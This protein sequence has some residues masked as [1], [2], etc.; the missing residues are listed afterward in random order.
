MCPVS[1][2]LSANTEGWTAFIS[3]VWPGVK[4]DGVWMPA[5]VISIGE[6][7]RSSPALRRPR[8]LLDLSPSQQQN[9]SCSAAERGCPLPKA[10]DLR[11]STSGYSSSHSHDQSTSEMANSCAEN[12]SDSSRE[13]ERGSMSETELQS[14]CVCSASCLHI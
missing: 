6:Q 4:A 10:A 1:G 2:T 8:R 14:V 3:T 5:V 9:H 7:G 11:R 12:G 13:E